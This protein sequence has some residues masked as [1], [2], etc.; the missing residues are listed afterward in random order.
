VMLAFRPTWHHSWAPSAG[1]SLRNPQGSG[2][3]RSLLDRLL[4]KALSQ[5][6]QQ[7]HCKK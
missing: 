5:T 2:F 6:S 4:S 1:L 7:T 3:L